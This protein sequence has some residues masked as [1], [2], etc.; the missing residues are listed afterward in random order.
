MAIGY[1]RIG[2]IMSIPR[3]AGSSDTRSVGGPG[4]HVPSEHAKEMP[5]KARSTGLKLAMGKLG[6]EKQRLGKDKC[7]QREPA[8]WTSHH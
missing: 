5:R 2:L 6:C 7:Y 8:D 1:I 4:G 3:N